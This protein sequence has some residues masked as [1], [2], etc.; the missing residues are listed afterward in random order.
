MAIKTFKP[1]TAARRNMT[2]SGFEQEFIGDRRGIECL[3]VSIAHDIRDVM[4]TLPVH[5]V[6]SIVTA[7]AHTYHLDDG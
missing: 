5:I 1:Y 3:L 4:N 7:A 6:D 2:V